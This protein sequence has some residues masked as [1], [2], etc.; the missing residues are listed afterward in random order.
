MTDI[1]AAKIQ[2]H[3]KN[4]QRYRTLLGSALTYAE[5]RYLERRIAQEQTAMDNL[6]LVQARERWPERGTRASR[7]IVIAGASLAKDRGGG[8]SHPTE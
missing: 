1:Q 2:A 4:I 3:R 5:R 7:L 6:Q 8:S